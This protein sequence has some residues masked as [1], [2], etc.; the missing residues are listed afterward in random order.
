MRSVRRRYAIC[1]AIACVHRGP[2]A[3]LVSVQDFPPLDEITP[4]LFAS[5]TSYEKKLALAA[6]KRVSDNPYP[7]TWMTKVEN[8]STLQYVQVAYTASWWD[9]ARRA[10]FLL[11]MPGTVATTFAAQTSLSLALRRWRA[12]ATC[13]CD[14]NCAAVR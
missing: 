1:A 13:G 4:D 2:C 5:L 11:V 3:S 14:R 6:Y 12:I 8:P 7:Y 9:L 10:I